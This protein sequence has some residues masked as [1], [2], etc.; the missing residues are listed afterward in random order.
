MHVF[1]T[2]TPPQRELCPG[3][4]EQPQNRRR[5]LINRTHCGR[6]RF[7]CHDLLKLVMTHLPDSDLLNCRLVSLQWA[8]QSAAEWSVVAAVLRAR[9][10]EHRRE[11]NKSAMQGAGVVA[12][13]VGM[14]LGALVLLAAGTGAF[15]V[16]DGFVGAAVTF[17]AAIVSRV[18]GEVGLN[19]ALNLG[20]EGARLIEKSKDDGELQKARAQTLGALRQ[21]D[22]H[23]RPVHHH[24]ALTVV[25]RAKGHDT[26]LHIGGE[27][28]RGVRRR[29][30]RNLDDTGSEPAEDGG[31]QRQSGSVLEEMGFSE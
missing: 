10:E 14:G 26:E 24:D 4:V 3:T 1:G 27:R 18:G 13:S 20:S 8:E 11:A 7:L 29:L 12:L 9:S 2:R 6:R 23:G 21:G 19:A 22:D 25:M 28:R 16:A 17:P 5:W 15:L 31:R 30:R